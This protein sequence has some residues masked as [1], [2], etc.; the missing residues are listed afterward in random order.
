MLWGDLFSGIGGFSLALQWA[1]MKTAWMVEIEPYCQKILRQNF[2]GIPIYEDIRKLDYSTVPPI[3]GLCGGFP[4]QPFSVAGRKRGKEDAR[5][6][7]PEYLRAIKEL[8]PRYILAEN[9]PGL[10]NGYLDE[11]LSDLEDEAYEA[12]TFNIPACSF[13][14]PHRRERIWIVAYARLFGSKKFEKQTERI[15]QCSKNVSHPKAIL[16]ERLNERPREIQSWRSDWWKI[17]PNVGRVADGVPK[18]M[19]RLKALGNAIVPQVAHWI[20]ERIKEYGRS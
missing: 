8:R 7:W 10:N 5:N 16:L 11:I 3:D 2:P 6:L 13:E 14:A 12:W 20:F 9:V 17:E 19:D 15:I 4:C 1:G 18:R